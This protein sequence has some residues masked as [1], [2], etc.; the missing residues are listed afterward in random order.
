MSSLTVS[1]HTEQKP[2]IS[3]ALLLP[4]KDAVLGKHYELSVAFVGAAEMRRLNR[5]YRGKDTST[6]IL[7]FPLSK[8]SGEIVF[9]PADIRS[10]APLFG[11]EVKNFLLFL[12]IHGLLHL[13]G[14]R[15]GSRMEH[16]EE[17]IRRKCKV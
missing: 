10:Q 16:E 5:T 17:K 8:D 11:R 3:R 7:S 6:D 13:K 9:S 15:H 4:V 1:S 2:R 14:M 12:F